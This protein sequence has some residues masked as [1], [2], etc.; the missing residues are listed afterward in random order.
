MDSIFDI[1]LEELRQ[2]RSAKWTH[3]P[4]DVLPLPVAEMDVRLAPSVAAALHAAVERSD[5]GYAG[6]S[7]ELVE[8]FR[9]FAW[10]RW[11]W[12]VEAGS[13]R[14]CADLAVGMTEVLRRLVRPGDGVVV[15]PPVYPPFYAWLREAGAESVPVPLL[16]QQ[17]G[18]RLDLDGID[19]VLDGGVRVVLLCH[20]HNPLGRVHDLDELRAL[21]E[22]ARRHGAIVLSDEIHGP[23]THPGHAFHPYLTVSDAAVETGIAFTSASKAFNLAGLKC[24]L[25]VTERHRA[26]F[27]RLPHELGWGVGHLGVLAATTAFTDGDDWLDRL[28]GRLAANAALLRDLLAERLP[29]VTFPE[30]QATYLAWLDCSSLGFGPDPAATFLDRARVAL[31][32]GPDFGSPG[33]GYA[34]FNYAC[35]SALIEEAV[36]RM[37]KIVRL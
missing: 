27:D 14:T 28:A 8:A 23:L 18:G 35:S 33:Q 15:M 13:V 21:A 29:S 36:A 9:G 5:T 20:P 4:P 26:M 19:R 2:R 12:Q 10:R 11:R 24:A 34:R 32:S 6:D 3:H 22:I 30:P 7:G 31:S 17:R 16:E 25:I 1:P 37:A